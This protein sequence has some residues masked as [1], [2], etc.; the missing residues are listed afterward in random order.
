MSLGLYLFHFLALFREQH[1]KM[2]QKG[3]EK[4]PFVSLSLCVSLLLKWMKLKEIN[5]YKR[6]RS[7]RRRRRS[8]KQRKGE[9]VSF[10]ILFHT[11]RVTNSQRQADTNRKKSILRKASQEI[12][13]RNRRGKRKIFYLLLLLCLRFYGEMNPSVHHVSYFPFI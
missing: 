4:F 7:W 13:F 6:G 11:H 12:Q 9:K 3:G 8:N 10:S 5:S 1:N 2:R